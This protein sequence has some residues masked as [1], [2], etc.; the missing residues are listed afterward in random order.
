MYSKDSI[1]FN[2]FIAASL[3]VWSAGCAVVN[4]DRSGQREGNRQAAP[5]ETFALPQQQAPPNEIQSIQLHPEG[6]PD[7]PP[8]IELDAGQKLVLSFDY[9]GGESRQFKVKV[10]HR[11]RQWDQSPLNPSFFLDSFSETQIQESKAS[12]S[13]RPSYHHVE[14]N[15]PNNELRPAVSGNYLIEVYSNENGELLFSMPFFVTEDEGSI[16]TRIERLFAQRDD[17]RPMDQLFST[18]QYPDFVEY[19]QFDLS[20]FFVQNRFWGRM[21]EAGFLDTITPGEL[22]GHQ[23][24]NQAF[25]GNYEFKYLDL[26]SFDADGQQ[27]L[28]YQPEVTPAR[29]ILRRDIQN[30]DSDPGFFTSSSNLGFPL[31]DRNSEYA[32][33]E[34]RLETNA[35]IP[36]SSDIYIVGQFNNWMVNEL[37]KMSFNTE[38]EL[39]EGRAFIKQGEYAYKYILV[40]NNRINDLALDH[41]FLSPRQLYLTLIYFRDPDRHYD[42]LLKIDSVISE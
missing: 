27:I 35:S 8:V 9:L 7:M 13:Q 33:I 21:Q 29:I 12:F 2:F 25:V 17:G 20:M 22:H 32:Q 18:Y 15:F 14:Y 42:R 4:Q 38:E 26:R 3:L 1:C 16:E 31:N 23:E 19:P 10:S 30:L 24:R 36:L 37:N 40:E 39:W 34:F 41:S 6:N 5:E 11:T 28:E